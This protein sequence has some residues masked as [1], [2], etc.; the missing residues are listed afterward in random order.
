MNAYTCCI[1]GKRVWIV[2]AKFT[3]CRVALLGKMRSLCAEMFI[4]KSVCLW[5]SFARSHKG[6]SW[7]ISSRN[8]RSHLAGWSHLSLLPV[9]CQRCAF[10]VCVSNLPVPIYQSPERFQDDNLKQAHSAKLSRTFEPAHTHTHIL[11]NGNLCVWVGL[12]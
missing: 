6:Y 5:H 8:V 3:W 12:Q 1:L 9:L 10:F 4:P 2:L 7:Y 11:L